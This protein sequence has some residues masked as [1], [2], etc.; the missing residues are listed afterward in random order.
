MPAPELADA[1]MA[2]PEV[3]RFLLIAGLQVSDSGG[4]TDE[5]RR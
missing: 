1:A 5:M 2:K 4:V 3:M